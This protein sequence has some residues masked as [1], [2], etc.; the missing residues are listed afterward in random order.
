MLAGVSVFPCWVPA[1]RA[2]CIDPL[3]ALR[4]DCDIELMCPSNLACQAAPQGL[5]PSFLDKA[6]SFRSFSRH[7][8]AQFCIQPS[9]GG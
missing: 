5:A 8:V 3:I 4:A 6:L 9:P 7:R 1:W 2:S